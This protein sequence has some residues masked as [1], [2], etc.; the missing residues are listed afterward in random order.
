MR[1]DT[2][3]NTVG[4]RDFAN[5]WGSSKSS[6]T[7]QGLPAFHAP[8]AIVRAAISASRKHRVCPAAPQSDVWAALGV[9]ETPHRMVIT[10]RRW[11]W[12]RLLATIHKCQLHL[13]SPW[14][15]C[16]STTNAP[17]RQPQRAGAGQK[18]AAHPDLFSTLKRRHRR[19][20][21]NSVQTRLWAGLR[22]SGTGGLRS[23]AVPPASVIDGPE[24]LNGRGG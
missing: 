8:W 15:W 2:P 20:R 13:K 10:W 9:R 4:A 18:F 24:R 5:R 22:T 3:T 6:G 12:Q 21:T 14:L 17:T 19:W 11:C 7:S 16:T 23:H 1:N